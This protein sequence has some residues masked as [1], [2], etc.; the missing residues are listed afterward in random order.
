MLEYDVAFE[1]VAGQAELVRRGE[2]SARELVQLALG[3]I[4]RI[5][6]ELNAFGAVLAEAASPTPT[7][8]TSAGRAAT[9]R[10]CSACRWR[11]RTRSTSRAR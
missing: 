3:R 8:R 2:A 1:G 5:D 9:G 7:A 4:E 10:R 6:G 11:S